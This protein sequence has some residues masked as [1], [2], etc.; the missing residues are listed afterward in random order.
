MSREHRIRATRPWIDDPPVVSWPLLFADDAERVPSHLRQLDRVIP[1]ESLTREPVSD[2]GHAIV[3]ACLNSYG[4][5]G[6]KSGLE[7]KQLAGQFD[8]CSRAGPY[9]PAGA[10]LARLIR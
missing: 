10:R 8:I 6:A 7:Q 3:V 4:K 9:G 1:A 5:V 2:F